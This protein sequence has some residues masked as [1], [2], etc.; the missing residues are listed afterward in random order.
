MSQTLPLDEMTIEEKLETMEELWGDLVRRA[1]HVPSPEWH[2]DV[3]TQRQQS[4]KDGTDRPIDWND[5]KQK[6]K[7]GLE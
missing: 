7:N 2:K 4:V 3:L 6:L 1:E 5:A